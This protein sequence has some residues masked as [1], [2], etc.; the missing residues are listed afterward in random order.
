MNNTKILI[1]EDEAVIA[2]DIQVALGRMGYSVSGMASSGE[3][4]VEKAVADKPDLVL[5]DVRLKG[6]IDGIDAAARIRERVDIPV[7]YLSAYADDEILARAKMT[8]PYG[9]LLKPVVPKELQTTIEMALYRHRAEKQVSEHQRRLA[10]TLSC[11]GDGLIVTDTEASVKF[12]N[13]AAEQLTGWKRTEA[14]GK[15]LTSVFSLVREQTGDPEESDWLEVVRRGSTLRLEDKTLVARDGTHTLVEDSAAP[16]LDDCGNVTGMVLVFHDA[17]EKRKNRELM[18][19]SARLKAISDLAGGVAHNFNNLL[20]IIMGYAQLA[21]MDLSSGDRSQVTESLNIILESCRSATETV[22]RLQDFARIR[23]D[24]DRT[25]TDIVDFSAVVREA[26]ELNYSA[27][28]PGSCACE[29]KPRMDLDLVPDCMVR[30]NLGQ[31]FQVALHLVAN[32]V[33]ATSPGGLVSVRTFCDAD[34]VF[35]VVSDTGEGIPAQDLTNVFLPFWTSKGPL[36]TGMG[37]SS[38]YGIVARHNGEIHITSR[39]GE[40]TTATVRLPRQKIVCEL[41]EADAVLGPAA[42]S[43]RILVIDDVEPVLHLLRRE[44]SRCGHKVTTASSG[45]EGLALFQAAGADLVICDLG[46]EDMN[47][48]AV[49]DALQSFCHEKACPKPPF[50]LLTGWD[51]ESLRSGGTPGPGVDRSLQKPVEMTLLLQ[52]IEEI[53]GRQEQSGESN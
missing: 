10:A 52:T 38:S 25:D 8:H 30:G 20:Q 26:T 42:V 24:G 41:P 34:N 49:S 23:S 18:L 21:Q 1:V 28:P 45:A 14:E 29:P 27:Q 9:Y 46:M 13:R 6:G 15:D 22:K 40:G 53:F 44:L 7:V 31:L 19:Q 16:I 48:W 3:G 37:L 2:T 32:A 43:L 33:E 11:I 12:M 51:V 39:I 5:M 17:S 36:R 4:A 47:G 50:I 35:L